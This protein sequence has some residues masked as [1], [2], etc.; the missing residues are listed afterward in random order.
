MYIF[1]TAPGFYNDTR[2]PGKPILRAL[3]YM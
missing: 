1:S 2:G 3:Y